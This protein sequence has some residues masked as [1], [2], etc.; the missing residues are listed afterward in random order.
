MTRSRWWSALAI[1]TLILLACAYVGALAYGRHPAAVSVMITDQ[2][3]DVDE[4]HI[5]AIATNSGQTPLTYNGSPP[6]SELRLQ[7]DAGWTDQPQRYA[8]KRSSLG[9]L[10]PGERMTYQFTVPRG[11]VRVQVG[12][13]YETSGT[14][15]WV[16]RRFGGSEAWDRFYPIVRMI[17]PLVPDGRHEDVE[18]W[19][20]PTEVK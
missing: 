4:I 5:T 17:L 2:K 15:G 3:Q 20:P 14:R 7:T 11:T 10:L 19:S 13:Y 16:V 9:F 6:F 8:S 18:F 1:V 12:C